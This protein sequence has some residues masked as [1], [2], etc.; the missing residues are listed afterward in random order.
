MTW[1]TVSRPASSSSPDAEPVVSSGTSHGASSTGVAATATTG[2]PQLSRSRSSRGEMKAARPSTTAVASSAKSQSPGTKAAPRASSRAVRQAARQRR[3]RSGSTKPSAA[4][5][6]HGSSAATAT[7]PKRPSRPRTRRHRDEGVGERSPHDQPA[8][9]PERVDEVADHLEQAPRTPRGERHGQ[10][11]EGRRRRR[12]CGRAAPRRRRRTAGRRPG[13]ARRCRCRGA[14]R[15]RCAAPP[16]ADRGR[17]RRERAAHDRAERLAGGEQGEH[18]EEHQHDR[19]GVGEEARHEAA[20][21]E[22]GLLVVLRR[23]RRG[24]RRCSCRRQERPRAPGDP[25]SLGDVGGLAGQ[26]RRPGR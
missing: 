4:W 2:G 17:H 22:V 23:R 12:R 25:A 7:V 5:A 13:P 26:R 24:P 11:H 6:A 8:R 14:A 20:V 1:S 3:S 18:P 9:Q 21:G 16:V 19:D 15:W 10:Q